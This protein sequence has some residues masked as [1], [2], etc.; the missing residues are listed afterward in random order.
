MKQDLQATNR[1]YCSGL[2]IDSQIA[3]PELLHGN[4]GK[5][6]A[7]TI[8]IASFP[9]KLE[10]ASVNAHGDYSNE[11]CFLLKIG[12]VANFLISN[13]NTILVN[14]LPDVAEDKYRIF[15]LGSA[16]GILMHQRKILP[17]HASAIVA[18]GRAIAFVGDSGAGKSTLAAFLCNAGYEVICDDVGAMTYEHSG[19]PILCPGM[20]L[21][22]I[23]S[24]TLKEMEQTSLK[25]QPDHGQAN[26]FFMQPDRL[27]AKPV[28][29]D[30]IYQLVAGKAGSVPEITRLTG[31]E[32][33]QA[34][35]NNIYRSELLTSEA[36]MVNIFQQCADIVNRIGM[37]K[38]SRPRDFS[39]MD[40]GLSVLT[41]HILCNKS[42]LNSD[43]TVVNG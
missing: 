15:L 27:S 17:L 29:L 10:G 34:L 23:W 3:L 1:Y 22:K 8:R 19:A 18:E 43:T 16:M 30:S 7:V 12:E 36:I 11:T 33:M 2:E 24:D 31:C 25:S 39:S 21:I 40:D 28:V 4:T 32:K 20:I 6:P 26:K 41:K 35:V 5:P 37:Y 14:P 9:D 42:G 38:F 13:G